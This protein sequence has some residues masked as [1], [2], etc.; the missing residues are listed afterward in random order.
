[1]FTSGSIYLASHSG[2]EIKIS[3]TK[4]FFVITLWLLRVV[5]CELVSLG[6]KKTFY[7]FKNK[8]NVNG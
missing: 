7:G 5:T 3:Q 4:S 6:N 8:I 1:M 2:V